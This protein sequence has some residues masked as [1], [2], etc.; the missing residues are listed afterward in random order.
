MR[1]GLEHLSYEE[2][3]RELG[4]PQRDHSSGSQG[5]GWAP[6]PPTSRLVMAGRVTRSH[7]AG[8]GASGRYYLCP[9][10]FSCGGAGSAAFP[11]ATASLR[12]RLLQ[13]I[14]KLLALKGMHLNGVH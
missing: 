1:R 3:L 9:Q 12:K 4:S 10:V 13:L 11:W 7:Q 2:R 5:E 8:G 14:I 6:L